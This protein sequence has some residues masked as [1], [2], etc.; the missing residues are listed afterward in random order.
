MIDALQHVL[1]Q[2]EQ[3]EPIIQETLARRF[4]QVI[5]EELEEAASGKTP[6][7]RTISKADREAFLSAAGA[8]KGI[9]DAE[10]LKE[11]IYKTRGSD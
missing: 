10:R 7:E 4:R 2:V 6:K 8:W 5:K 1:E 9:V 3:L 11:D